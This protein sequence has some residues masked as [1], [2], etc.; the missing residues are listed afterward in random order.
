M[1]HQLSVP[2]VPSLPAP[3]TINPCPGNLPP[4]LIVSFTCYPVNFD[5]SER[6]IICQRGNTILVKYA[7]LDHALSQASIIA[8]ERSGPILLA[9][10]SMM[11]VLS[12]DS[13]DLYLVNTAGTRIIH[14]CYSHRF[15]R[16][17][18][19]FSH[20]HRPVAIGHSPAHRPKY[21]QYSLPHTTTL[22]NMTTAKKPLCSAHRPTVWYLITIKRIHNHT[23]IVH[24][25]PDT[26]HYPRFR[27][28]VEC[29]DIS[30]SCV[31]LFDNDAA[32][33]LL[34]KTA[35]EYA[36]LDEAAT[37]TRL[38]SAVGKVFNAEIG[39]TMR[40]DMS[41]SAFE[42]ITLCDSLAFAIASSCYC[43]SD[44]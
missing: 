15:S 41:G 31:L 5:L 7:S 43:E 30:T 24:Y 36:S 17:R 16:L 33:S 35:R 23:G 9:F 8:A 12:E 19:M 4:H 20:E 18:E 27:M 26:I 1:T 2:I 29:K 14:G 42:V 44:F 40:T 13:D 34:Q 38:Q 6:W 22:F 37:N 28:K 32:L 11:V 25:H 10:T 39:T 21:V 3:I